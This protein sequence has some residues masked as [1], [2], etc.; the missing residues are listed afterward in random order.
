LSSSATCFGSTN[1]QQELLYICLNSHKVKPDVAGS[2]GRV[3]EGVGLRPLACWD[4]GFEYRWGPW[5]SVQRSPTDF[6]AS[7]CVI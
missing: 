7:L 4:C 6:G 5:M 3:I 2:S 1:Q